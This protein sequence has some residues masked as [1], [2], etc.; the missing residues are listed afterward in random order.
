MLFQSMSYIFRTLSTKE[1][2][3]DVIRTTEDLVLVLCFGRAS[4]LTCMRLEEIVSVYVIYQFRQKVALSFKAKRLTSLSTSSR[5]LKLS[6]FEK[7]MK[8]LHQAAAGRILV[9]RR[10]A[11]HQ[12]VGVFFA[13]FSAASWSFNVK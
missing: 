8:T 7:R 3:D 1:M 9:V 11:C 4:D 13:I 6:T 10:F 2:V 5:K 12:L